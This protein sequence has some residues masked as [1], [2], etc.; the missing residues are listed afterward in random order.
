MSKKREIKTYIKLF[1]S[2]HRDGLHGLAGFTHTKDGSITDMEIAARYLKIKG[3]DIT[4][5]TSINENAERLCEI[6]LD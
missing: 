3:M 5:N 6:I 1:R 4:L 2:L